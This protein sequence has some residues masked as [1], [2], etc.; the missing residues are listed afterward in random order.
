MKII[1]EKF[2][3]EKQAK[4]F[5]DESIF[6]MLDISFFLV[7]NGFINQGRE[8]CEIFSNEKYMDV[9]AKYK[10]DFLKIKQFLGIPSIY[11]DRNITIDNLQNAKRNKVNN[12]DKE[13]LENYTEA[14]FSIFYNEF[15]KINKK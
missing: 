8:F 13:K 14:F 11:L 2:E 4:E 15:E 12:V 1:T 5:W 10:F 9:L 3:N 6:D 7:D